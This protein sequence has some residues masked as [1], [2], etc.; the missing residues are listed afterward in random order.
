MSIKAAP[1]VM[2]YTEKKKA[3][4]LCV[5]KGIGDVGVNPVLKW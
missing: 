1:G 5:A 2:H 3:F 4:R